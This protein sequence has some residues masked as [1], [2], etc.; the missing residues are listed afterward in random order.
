MPPASVG[1]DHVHP[2][3]RTMYPRR[4]MRMEVAFMHF[5]GERGWQVLRGG[6]EHKVAWLAGRPDSTERA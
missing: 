4:D 6:L 3:Q 5:P 1:R 2:G